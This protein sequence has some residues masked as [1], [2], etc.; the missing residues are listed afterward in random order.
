MET[1]VESLQAFLERNLRTVLSDLKAGK[2]TARE[3]AKALGGLESALEDAGLADRLERLR[4]LFQAEYDAVQSEFEQTTGKK[5]LLG[6]FARRN[7]E[8]IVDDRI[9][10]ASQTINTYLGDVRSVVLDSVLA[11]K[12]V[13]VSEVLRDAEGATMRNLKTEI[14]TSLM[15]YQRAAH[16]EKSR[17]AGVTKFLYVGPEDKVT[18]DFCLDRVDTV[19]SLQEIE[20]MDNGQGLPVIIYGGGYNCRHH[21]RPVSDDLAEE[22]EG[23]GNGN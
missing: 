20:A 2:L 13:K 6:D 8:V 10:M 7:L 19:Y 5:A 15:A 17:K 21:W 18:R 22:L 3:A 4:G 12:D 16:L 11:G 14:N 23:E 1:L 9:A